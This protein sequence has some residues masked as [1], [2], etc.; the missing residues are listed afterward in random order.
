[1]LVSAIYRAGR[2]PIT[3]RAT[4]RKDMREDQGRG[5]IARWQCFVGC[6][7]SLAQ[8]IAVP[9]YS[10]ASSGGPSAS[11]VQSFL[12][13]TV[14]LDKRHLKCLS[15][16]LSCATSQKRAL[17]A[18]R[19]WGAYCGNIPMYKGIE[20]S[21]W[22]NLTHHGR[23]RCVILAVVSLLVA[24]VSVLAYHCWNRSM[25]G[26]LC[27]H[28]T[29]LMVVVVRPKYRGRYQIWSYQ[30]RIPRVSVESS[31][32]SWRMSGQHSPQWLG[33]GE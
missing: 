32:R 22:D 25:T 21:A 27:F 26:T 7:R 8:Q 23:W 16:G 30:I 28:R 31:W 33:L 15:S 1:M 18:E 5:C 3:W 4:Q 11:N 9:S 10:A 14:G 17:G 20:G 24:R 29:W 13:D 19:T 12:P 2:Q 6:A